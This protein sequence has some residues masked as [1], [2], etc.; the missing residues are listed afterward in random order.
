MT[1][2]YS[3]IEHELKLIKSENKKL[4]L[5]I[6]EKNNRIKD[7][8]NIFQTSKT[9]F[10]LFNQ[11][12]NSLQLKIIDLESKLKNYPN[13]NKKIEELNNKIQEYETK[14]QQ[15]KEEYLKKEELYKIKISNQERIS[16]STNRANDEEISELKKENN[17][18][19][20]SYDLLKK[21]NEE[22][23][24]EKNIIEENYNKKLNLK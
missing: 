10:D 23:F 16:Q 1:Q 7:F 5:T 11:T 14:F 20:N 22:I 6:K 8:Q 2:N 12:N 13:L 4:K 19:K 21:Q 3:L 15:I 24:E 18:I 17:N 9:K